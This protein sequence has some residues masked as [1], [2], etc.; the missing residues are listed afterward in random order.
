MKADK[1]LRGKKTIDKFGAFNLIPG[2]W[3]VITWY[4]KKRLFT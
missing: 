2:S 3:E 4:N 1:R